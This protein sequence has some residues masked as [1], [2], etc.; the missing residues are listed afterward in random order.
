VI[1]PGHNVDIHGPAATTRSAGALLVPYAG[2]PVLRVVVYMSC[3]LD[4]IPALVCTRRWCPRS[5]MTADQV[6]SPVPAGSMQRC[7]KGVHCW[8]SPVRSDWSLVCSSRLAAAS[9]WPSR[10]SALVVDSSRMSRRIGYPSQDRM[11]CP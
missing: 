8:Q 3:G 10:K 6:P 1:D 4:L 5:S 9:L 7:Q 11:S 2:R